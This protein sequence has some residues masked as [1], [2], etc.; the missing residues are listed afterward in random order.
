MLF[1]ISRNGGD[2]I[3]TSLKAAESY[4]FKAKKISIVLLICVMLITVLTM[5]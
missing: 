3:V 2:M 4:R 5:G 1:Y